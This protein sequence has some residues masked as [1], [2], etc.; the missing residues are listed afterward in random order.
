[1]TLNSSKEC[2]ISFM[3]GTEEFGF[4]TDIVTEIMQVPKINKLPNTSD[5]LLG[6]I[7]VKDTIIPIIDLK[8]KLMGTFT[9]ITK[10]CRIVIINI[11]YSEVGLLVE[12][13][14]KNSSCE[15]NELEPVG[16]TF[17]EVPQKYLLGTTRSKNNIV[18]ILNGEAIL[19]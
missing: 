5:Y 15:F 17:S 19:G 18:K 7:K 13:L 8:K 16:N 10:D 3:L 6:V 2:Q 14:D 1:M 4:P 12:R 11:N 9:G